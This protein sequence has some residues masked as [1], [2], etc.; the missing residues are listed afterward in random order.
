MTNK[1]RDAEFLDS[2]GNE[3]GP[4][5]SLLLV[6][7]VRFLPI[8]LMQ[9]LY[10]EILLSCFRQIATNSSLARNCCSEP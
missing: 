6:Y 8:W 2:S 7:V 4:A 3:R 1:R 5:A 10:G 9:R